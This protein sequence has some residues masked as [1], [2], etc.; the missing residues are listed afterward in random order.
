MKSRNSKIPSFTI[1]ACFIC[2]SIIGASMIPLLSVQLNPSTSLPSLSVNYSWRNVSAKVIEQEVTSKLE[3]VF[4]TVKGIK[5]INSTTDKENGFINIQFKKQ[6]DLDAVRF[7][8][9][10]LI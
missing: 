8:I 4:N 3:G 5:E 1:L 7:E 10:N 9:A 2:L 6:T